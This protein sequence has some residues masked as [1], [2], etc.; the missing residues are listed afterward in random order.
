MIVHIKT[1]CVTMDEQILHSSVVFGNG[2]EKAWQ[3]G[4]PQL[5][6][7]GTWQIE[8]ISVF[9]FVFFKNAFDPLNTFSLENID[10]FESNLIFMFW[11][12]TI[13]GP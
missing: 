4:I 7:V 9:C 13:E 12:I 3:C 11:L 6:Q 10:M 1:G 2:S 8:K 5:A